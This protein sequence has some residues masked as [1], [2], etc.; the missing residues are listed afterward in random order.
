MQKTHKATRFQVESFWNSRMT[1]KNIIYQYQHYL[2]LLK[3]PA[4]IDG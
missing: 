2:L 1:S 4:D 3:K